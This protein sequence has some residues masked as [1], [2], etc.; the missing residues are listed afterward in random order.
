MDRRLGIVLIRQL[1]YNLTPTV[2]MGAVMS[3][4]RSNV[5]NLRLPFASAST[6]GAPTE[7]RTGNSHRD[8]ELSERE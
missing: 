7:R 8:R 4:F 2:V 6:V 5:Y 3:M 1:E